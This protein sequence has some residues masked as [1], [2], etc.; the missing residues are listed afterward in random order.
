VI[1]ALENHGGLT[2]DAAGTLALVEPF[3]G[4]PWVRLNLDFGNFTGDIYGQYE[5]CAPCTA[6]THTKVTVRQGEGREPI[7]YRRVVRIMRAAGYNGY[8][9]IEYE[10]KEPPIPAVERFA[11]YL[12]GCIVDA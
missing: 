6:T 4:N 12:R 5:A 11:A 7:D 2:A 9:S 1:L 8:I 10:E 3:D